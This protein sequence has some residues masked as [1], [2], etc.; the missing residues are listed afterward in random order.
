MRIRNF[1]LVKAQNYLLLLIINYKQ[2][3]TKVKFK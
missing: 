1:A 2:I 3:K